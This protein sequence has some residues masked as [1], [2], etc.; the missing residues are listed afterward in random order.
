MGC[1]RVRPAEELVRVTQD[2]SGALVLGRAKPGR[3]AWLC[4][5]SPGCVE[6][7]IRRRAFERA[8]R[9]PV[10]RSAVEALRDQVVRANKEQ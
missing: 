5:D 6:A 2:R 9:H 8:L 4:R 1:R 3:G 7:A 10:A